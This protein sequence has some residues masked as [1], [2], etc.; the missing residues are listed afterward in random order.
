MHRKLGAEEL[1]LDDLRNFMRGSQVIEK[2]HKIQVDFYMLFNSNLDIL[3]KNLETADLVNLITLF[4]TRDCR[5]LSIFNKCV[6]LDSFRISENWI[7]ANFKH[8]I[9]KLSNFSMFSCFVK[10][11]EGNFYLNDL[12]NRILRPKEV[13]FFN[14]TRPIRSSDFVVQNVGIIA[15]RNIIENGDCYTIFCVSKLY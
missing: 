9:Y 14:K 2:L 4:K 15:T 3:Q 5:F 12:H 10:E 8:S 1:D 6:F 7:H 11:F 13:E